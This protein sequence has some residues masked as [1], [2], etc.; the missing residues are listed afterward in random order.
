MVFFPQQ[1][2]NCVVLY[3]ICMYQAIVIHRVIPMH[4][5]LQRIYTSADLYNIPRPSSCP[6]GGARESERA[7]WGWYI[8]INHQATKTTARLLMQHVGGGGE[9]SNLVTRAP[10]VTT[11]RL[12]TPLC[13]SVIDT[14]VTGR[15]LITSGRRYLQ[16]QYKRFTS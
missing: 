4:S 2:I 13:R 5:I 3:T 15:G 9:G 16:D 8:N 1:Y 11:S 10:E 7:I 14:C 6:P 12:P